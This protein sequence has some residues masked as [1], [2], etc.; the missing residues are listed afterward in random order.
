MS[1]SV[2]CT[3]CWTRSSRY[4]EHLIPGKL[5]I[6]RGNSDQAGIAVCFVLLLSVFYTELRRFG[7]MKDRCCSNAQLVRTKYSSKMLGM[8]SEAVGIFCLSI[9]HMQTG[10]IISD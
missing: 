4:A 5:D 3:S 9:V 2:A 7:I 1:S 6:G 10:T 8:M